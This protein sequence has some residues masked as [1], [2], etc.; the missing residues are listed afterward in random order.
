VHRNGTDEVEGVLQKRGNE[1]VGT[2]TAKV[3]SRQ[4]VRGMFGIGDCTAGHYVDSQELNVVGRRSIPS[5]CPRSSAISP[6]R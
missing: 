1:Y 2:V 4:T 5:S 6:R 3:D